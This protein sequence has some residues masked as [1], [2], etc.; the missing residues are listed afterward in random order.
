MKTSILAIGILALVSLTVDNVTDARALKVASASVVCP[1]AKLQAAIDAAA[2][3]VP[4]TIKVSG[5]CVETIVVPEGKTIILRGGGKAE[6]RPP[7][8]ASMMPVVTNKGDLTLI[9]MKVVNLATTSGVLLSDGSSQ[10]VV[11]GSTIRGDNAEVAL[12]VGG[13]SSGRIF[14]SSVSSNVGEGVGVYSQATAEIFG[15]PS[16]VGHPTYGYTSR[17]SSAG[18]D[19]PAISCGQGGNLVIRAEGTGKVI[20]RSPAG[21]AVR[22]QQCTFLVRNQ[23][24]SGA[25]DISSK[26]VAIDLI[27]SQAILQRATLQSAADVGMALSQSNAQILGVVFKKSGLGDIVADGNS[28]LKFKGWNGKSSLLASFDAGYQA[29]TC[30]ERSFVFVGDGDVI[31]P[32]GRSVPDLEGAYPDCFGLSSP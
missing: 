24:S 27:L 12:E 29:L 2:P 32:T 10:L 18:L 15:R 7:A 11:Y 13:S 5:I 21:T 23:A 17:I 3:G 22:A 20:V 4:T 31:L 19:A 25:V 28:T 16:V 1:T 9:Q 26:R 30:S 8:A 6:L 14:N